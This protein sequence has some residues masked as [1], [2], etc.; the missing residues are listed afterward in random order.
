[1]VNKPPANA[2][3]CRF[4]PWSKEDPLQK[5]MVTHSSILTWKNRM[6]R[7][8]WWATVH[9]VTKV[10]CDLMTEQQQQSYLNSR[11]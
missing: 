4:D 9:G 2:G 11:A 1:M 7:R 8:A 5:E 6:D 10:K 3:E